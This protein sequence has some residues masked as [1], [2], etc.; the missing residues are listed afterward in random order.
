ME[1]VKNQATN[2][3]NHGTHWRIEMEVSIFDDASTDET[4]L[5]IQ[6]W[7]TL[8]GNLPGF[9]VVHSGNESGNPRGG[10]L[11]ASGNPVGLPRETVTI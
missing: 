11:F 4:P 1:S 10:K 5:L 2:V 7:A 6:K 3:D 9:V 8:L